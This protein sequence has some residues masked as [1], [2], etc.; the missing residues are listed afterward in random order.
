M[1]PEGELYKSSSTI[2]NPTM[3]NHKFERVLKNYECNQL[4]KI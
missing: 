3:T 1:T 4:A 2:L